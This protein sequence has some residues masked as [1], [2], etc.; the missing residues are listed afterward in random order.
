MERL[1]TELEKELDYSLQ[2]LNSN[3]SNY[4]AWH[5]RSK[6]IP[7]VHSVFERENLFENEIYQQ[8]KI[9][10]SLHYNITSLGFLLFN[11]VRELMKVYGHLHFVLLLLIIYVIDL[12]FLSG[13]LTYIH[14]H[15][16]LEVSMVESAVYTDPN[17]QSAW[18]YHR[19]LLGHISSP[20]QFIQ[21]GYCENTG[22]AWVVVYPK[23]PSMIVKGLGD[24]EWEFLN[25]NKV[26]N[27]LVSMAQM[28]SVLCFLAELY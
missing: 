18:F 13:V 20:S 7:R 24:S 23:K 14:L 15:L 26:S 25:G 21:A 2:K 1:G 3:F 17:D 9:P 27:V 4:S 28:C 5:Y 8:G 12:Y 6:L 16:F 19:W 10:M 22:R 11:V